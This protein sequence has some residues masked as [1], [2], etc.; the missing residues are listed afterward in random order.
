MPRTAD[1]HWAERIPG[2]GG[3]GDQLDRGNGRADTRRSPF[4]DV[5]PDSRDVLGQ[6]VGNLAEP[7]HAG[8]PFAQCGDGSPHGLRIRTLDGDIDG[9]RAATATLSGDGDGAQI[10]LAVGPVAQP[11]L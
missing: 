9:S 4:V 11:P 7:R 2:D 8:H 3:R 10:A 5:D 1:V 6:V